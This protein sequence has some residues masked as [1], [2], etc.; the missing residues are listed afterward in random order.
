MPD[1]K[2]EILA[3]RLLAVDNEM[4]AKLSHTSEPVG[5]ADL[6]TE[7]KRVRFAS[8]IRAWLKVA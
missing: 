2:I 8:I 7:G 5:D 3:E 4:R 6:W 1:P